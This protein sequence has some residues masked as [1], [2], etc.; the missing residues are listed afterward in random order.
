MTYEE[1]LAFIE[2]LSGVEAM[3]MLDNQTIYYSSGFEKNLVE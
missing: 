1:G 2:G 3:W